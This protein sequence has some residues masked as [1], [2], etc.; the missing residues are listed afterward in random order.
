[1]NGNFRLGVAVC[2]VRIDRNPGTM[3]ELYDALNARAT[4]RAAHLMDWELDR[5]NRA[6]LTANAPDLLPQLKT[7]AALRAQDLKGGAL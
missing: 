1:M 7:S 4:R 2:A 6:Y 5:L 3:A